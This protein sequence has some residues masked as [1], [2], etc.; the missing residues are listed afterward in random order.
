MKETLRVMAVLL[1]GAWLLFGVPLLLVGVLNIVGTTLFYTA[2]RYPIG[3]ENLSAAMWIEG[4]E[5]VRGFNPWLTVG[6]E[7]FI[8]IHPMRSCFVRHGYATL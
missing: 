6:K 5:M 4:R 1:G 7:L 2:S 3:V 8:S